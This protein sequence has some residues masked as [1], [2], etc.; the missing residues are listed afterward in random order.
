MQ[1]ITDKEKESAT[2]IPLERLLS[3]EDDTEAAF[4]DFR[5]SFDS[6][7]EPGVVRAWEL[8]IDE[9]GNVG[10]TR[11]QNRLGSWPIDA[12]KFD[13]LCQ[14]L[15]DQYMDVTQTRMAVRL[16]GTRKE[17]TGYVFNKI[18][19]LK[20]ALKK[21]SS[22]NASDSTAS[23]MKMMQEMNERNMAMF[24]R[25]QAPK[26]EKPDV[27]G[28]IQKMMAF[29]QAMNGPMMSMLQSLIPAL[30]GRPAPADKDPFSS[31]GGLLDVAERLSDLRGGGGEGGDDNSLA[32][33][34]RAVTPLA[35]PALEAL[36]AIAAMAARNSPPAPARIAAPQSVRTPPPGSV[37]TPAPAGPSGNG[38]ART[39]P[40]SNI[41][42]TDIPSGD[43]EMLAQLKP[44]I[45]ALVAMAAQGSPATDAADLLFDQ[46]FMTV[47]DEIFEK[48]AGFVD[49]DT[50]VNYVIVMNPAAKPHAAWFE[51]FKAQIVKRLNDETTSVDTPTPPPVLQG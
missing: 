46:V 34:L 32:G 42:P 20:R 35:K 4:N 16:C 10:T 33:I 24:A 12:Y 3:G 26:E 15:I 18:V 47:P 50:F 17:Q 2:I 31:I 44:Q 14:M 48:L 25:L 30:A 13:E 23:I 7:D 28:E 51:A 22:S 29:A 21:E 1:K 39:P 37:P 40:P 36:P 8:Q 6:S 41:Q 27:M 43:S 11:M 5:A 38:A 9:R 45:D 49:S 19:M